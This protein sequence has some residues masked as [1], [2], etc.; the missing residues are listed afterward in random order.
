MLLTVIQIVLFFGIPY[1]LVVLEN[2]S[3][4]IKTVGPIIFCYAIGIIWANSGLPLDASLSDTISSVLIPIAITLILLNSDFLTLKKNV[5]KTGLSF[6][7]L[8]ISVMS[9]AAISVFI[10]PNVYENSKIASML[11]GCYTGGTPNLFAIGYGVNAD[12]NTIIV[13]NLA[14][15]VLGGAYFLF[16]CTLAKPLLS[17][18]TKQ[19]SVATEKTDYQ[20]ESIVS[21]LTIPLKEKIKQG[22]IAILIGIGALGVS[23]GI[24]YLLTKQAT[25][26]AVIMLCVSLIGV[27]LSFVKGVRQNKVSYPL[28]QYF[29]YVFSLAVGSM[30]DMQLIIGQSVQVLGIVAFVLFA[31]MTLHFIL[32][33]LLKI[34]VDT[35]II[36][37]IAG[38]FGPAFI[39]PTAKA[40]K[41][42]G[43]I[44]IGIATGLLGYAIG[45][46]MGL[47][48][49]EIL[50]LI[51]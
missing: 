46:F 10:F 29:I 43:V 3:K 31:T 16:I 44:L 21:K 45:N 50:K 39:I 48:L 23:I 33:L 32:A 12:K 40:I 41:N 9:V 24:S 15:Q 42:E 28:G 18:F 37:S 13:A 4:F 47:S 22:V 2:K 8:C 11:V 19:I 7:L 34:D 30:A 6:L 38:I 49:Y 51:N 35:I 20:K 25:N 27:A 14:D 17:K 26:V 5:K 36:T 1:L